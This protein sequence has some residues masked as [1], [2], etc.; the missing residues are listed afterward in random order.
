M[1]ILLDV[2]L[3]AQD[4]LTADIMYPTYNQNYRNGKMDLHINGG[5]APY[6]VVWYRIIWDFPFNFEFVI[7]S[8]Y[9]IQGNN[10]GEDLM[11]VM[12]GFYRV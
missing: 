5:F 11:D 9:G 12:S 3:N 2:G 1:C 10:N 8:N 6:D 4:A 7:Q